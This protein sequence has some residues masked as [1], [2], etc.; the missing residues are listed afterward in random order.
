M[1]ESLLPVKLIKPDS[2]LFFN[3]PNKYVRSSC[4][5]ASTALCWA[6]GRRSGKI[7]VVAATLKHT[8]S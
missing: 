6:L 2:L 8:A 5:R 7:D 4:R 3:L 1:S